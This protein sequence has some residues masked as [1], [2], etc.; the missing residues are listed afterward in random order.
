MRI[1]ILINDFKSYSRVMCGI[2]IFGVLQFLILTFL[3]AFLYPG[4]YDYFGII[5]VI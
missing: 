1:N 5:S 3:A 2:T 4:G